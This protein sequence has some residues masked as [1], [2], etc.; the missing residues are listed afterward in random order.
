L[1]DT[2]FDESKVDYSPPNPVKK[3]HHDPPNHKAQ[4]KEQI[5]KDI[6][7]D[8]SAAFDELDKL[9]LHKNAVYMDLANEY[10]SQPNNFALAAFRGRL[11][12]FVNLNV[13]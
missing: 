1:L 10:I 3:E 5:L 7:N 12:R 6:N 9:F 4:L 11:R 2:E 8:M 13:Q